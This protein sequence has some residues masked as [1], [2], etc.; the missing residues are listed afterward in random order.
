MVGNLSHC[1]FSPIKPPT[2]A[3]LGAILGDSGRISAVYKASAQILTSGS[4]PRGQGTLC[5]MHKRP[6]EIQNP[7]AS[8]GE[9]KYL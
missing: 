8:I 4:Y 3:A 9:K 7:S 6:R 5:L 2:L 1:Y